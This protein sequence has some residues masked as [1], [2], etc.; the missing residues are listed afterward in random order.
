MGVKVLSNDRS[1]IFNPITGYGLELDIFMPALSKAI[2]YNGEYWHQ[3]KKRD[4][5][6][7]GLCK[8]K[9]I[10]LLIIWDKEWKAQNNICKNRIMGFLFDI[11]KK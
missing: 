9:D 4:L 10:D 7:Q 8:S 1:Q 3:D 5:L 2:E 6:K 11:K